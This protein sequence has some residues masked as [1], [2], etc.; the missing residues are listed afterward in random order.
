MFGKT[1]KCP[2]VFALAAVLLLAGLLAP[3]GSAMQAN[4]AANNA[5]V[6]YYT[7]YERSEDI[8]NSLVADGVVDAAKVE[9][10]EPMSSTTIW[11]S[12]EIWYEND[13]FDYL[14][15]ESNSYI[16]FEARAK[17]PTQIDDGDTLLMADILLELFSGWKSMGCKIMFISGTEEALL[18]SYDYGSKEELKDYTEFLDYVDIHVNTDWLTTIMGYIFYQA[19][20]ACGGNPI[21]DYTFFLDPRMFGDSSGLSFLSNWFTED[22]LLPYL[23]SA[24]YDETQAFYNWEYRVLESYDD[25][26]QFYDDLNIHLI[27]YDNDLLV[28]FTRLDPYGT[29]VVTDLSD[30]F[31]AARCAF[32]YMTCP[33]LEA[34]AW[35]TGLQDYFEE[36]GFYG[37]D[38]KV[39]VLNMTG[40][41][42]SAF[43]DPGVYG[44]TP[45]DHDDLYQVI[46]DF[47]LDDPY[48]WQYDNWNGR[49]QI[50]HKLIPPGPNS[51]WLDD[52]FPYFHVPGWSIYQP[53][54]A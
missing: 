51:G 3:S 50:T 36:W 27:C 23:L 13:V 15:V 44:L 20:L 28:P 47:L 17:F 41:S 1:K 21:G 11:Q 2:V 46:K 8:V 52:V 31:G 37:N 22:Y 53:E 4:A 14:Q 29:Y 43:S 30:Y 19:E 42:I 34:N 10:I 38:A 33:P 24:Y 12:L 48:L 5:N 16:I 45:G 40:Q 39:Y 9:R 25:F 54:V 49:C 7:D 6:Y 26:V 32:S 18:T 35:I